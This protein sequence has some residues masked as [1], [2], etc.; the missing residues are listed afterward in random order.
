MNVE[1][2]LA[3]RGVIVSHET[4][5]NWIYRFG[6]FFAACIKRDR[7]SPADKWHLDEVVIQ[8]RGET[9]FLFYD[10]P[11]STPWSLPPATETM[12]VICI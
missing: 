3:E 5:H 1:D 7:P 12:S 4:V 9:C 8:I 11:H 10:R 6:Q 2:L